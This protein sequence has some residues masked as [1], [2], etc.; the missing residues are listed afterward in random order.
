MRRLA[1]TLLL[2]LATAASP[3][4]NA[5]AVAPRV[6]ILGDSTARGAYAANPA[7]AYAGRLAVALHAVETTLVPA[8]GRLETAEAAWAAY[9]PAGWDVV[10]LAVGI[11]DAIAPSLP[12]DAWADRYRALAGRVAAGGATVVCAT[13]FDTGHAELA[14]VAARIAASCPGGAV[15]DVYAATQGRAELRAPAGA[16]TFFGVATDS[17]HPNDTGHARIA[18]IILAALRPAVYL[19]ALVQGA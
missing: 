16:P 5:T 11:N 13:P 8:G 4:L 2:A 15:A 18:A 12:P 10:V 3:G 6:L 17:Y 7:S 14:P 9:G 19:P 1:A